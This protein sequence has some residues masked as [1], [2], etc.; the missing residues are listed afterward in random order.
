M[1]ATWSDPVFWHASCCITV[2]TSYKIMRRSILYLLIITTLLYACN[3]ASIDGQAQEEH[4][5]NINYMHTNSPAENVQYIK[6]STDA[7]M[8][9]DIVRKTKGT[10]PDSAKTKANPLSKGDNS[11]TGKTEK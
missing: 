6:D 9:E 4:T 1:S 2:K 11:D 3:G 8:A 10:Q 7:A 5:G